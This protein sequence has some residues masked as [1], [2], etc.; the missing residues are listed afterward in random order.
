MPT[1][2]APETLRGHAAAIWVAA[3]NSAWDGKSCKDDCAAP[4]AWAAVKKK[5]TKNK[6]GRWVAKEEMKNFIGS[7]IFSATE[8]DFDD[9]SLSALVTLVKPGVSKNRKNWKPEA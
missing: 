7:D 3:F 4:I 9:E 2:S 6:E 1:R 5:Y 8:A